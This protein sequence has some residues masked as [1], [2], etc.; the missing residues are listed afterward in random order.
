MAKAT[1]PSLF[2]VNVDITSEACDFKIINNKPVAEDKCA[3][4]GGA[5]R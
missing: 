1:R 3:K 5:E 2:P 4:D